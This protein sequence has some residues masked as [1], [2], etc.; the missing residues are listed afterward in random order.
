MNATESD[1]EEI[2]VY[3][4]PAKH[5]LRPHSAVPKLQL[6]NSI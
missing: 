1:K 5:S 3:N 6:D 2:T 4:K